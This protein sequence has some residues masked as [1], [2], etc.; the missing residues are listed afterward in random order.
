MKRLR[1]LTRRRFIQL[2]ASVAAAGPV[3]SCTQATSPWRFLTAEE[4]RT[5]EAVCGQ[6]VPTDQDPG[7][8]EANVVNFID[9]QL[10]GHLKR[11]QKAYREGLAGV[12]QTSLALHNGRF[13]DL[14]AEKQLAVLV[15]LESGEAPGEIWR[16]RSARNFFALVVNHTM[17]GF[18]GDPRHGGNRNGASWK[19]LGLPYP[20]VRGR[21][22]DD[23]TQRT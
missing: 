4:A 13:A 12:D 2:T 23:L 20:P 22:Q 7:A 15:A 18:Y 1:K 17:Q 19:M 6:I 10:V 5:L 11:H 14:V 9:R 3:I 8:R 21:Q 16:R